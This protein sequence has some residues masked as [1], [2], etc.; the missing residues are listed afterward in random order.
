MNI[1]KHKILLNSKSSR[2]CLVSSSWFSKKSKMVSFVSVLLW[3]MCPVSMCIFKLLFF[4]KSSQ[5]SDSRKFKKSAEFV[6]IPNDL[7][8]P[9]NMIYATHK[10]DLVVLEFHLYLI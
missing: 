3:N 1:Q 9:S 6:E 4:I 2:N 7:T 5:I 10:K 8:L